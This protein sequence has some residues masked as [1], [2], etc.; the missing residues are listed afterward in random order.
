LINSPVDYPVDKLCGANITL[1]GHISNDGHS[2]RL[3]G[4]INYKS[5]GSDTGHYTAICK[6]KDSPDWFEYNDGKCT[7]E[8]IL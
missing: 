4:I 5:T 2:Y 1:D 7:G 6:L 3:F 8:F